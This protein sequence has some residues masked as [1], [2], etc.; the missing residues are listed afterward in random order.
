VNDSRTGHSAYM[1]AMTEADELLDDALFHVRAEESAGRITPA[2]AAAER[3]GLLER[4]L[5]DCRRL[6][7]EH[8]GGGQ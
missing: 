5:A 8:L 7:Q 2:D 3:V 4:H 6:R 1:A